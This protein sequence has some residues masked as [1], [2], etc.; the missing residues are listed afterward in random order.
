ML[1]MLT[2]CPRSGTQLLTKLCNT[3]PEVRITMELGSLRTLWV[4][5]KFY[6]LYLLSSFKSRRFPIIDDGSGGWRSRRAWWESYRFLFRLLWG[7]REFRFQDVGSREVESLYRKTT[8]C[9]VVGDKLPAYILNLEQYLLIENLRIVVIHRHPAA[10]IR[11]YL[12]LVQGNWRKIPTLNRF[13]NEAAVARLWAQS[14]EPLRRFGDRVLTIGYESLC[15]DP[16]AECR[17]LGE[18]FEVDPEGFDTSVVE[19]PRPLPC[20]APRTIDEIREVAGAEAEFL[21][22]RLS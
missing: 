22:Y 1:A 8:G 20:F 12:E 2:G 6:G 18:W 15:E 19:P 3:H 9:R 16:E 4:P 17:R 7:L 10:V 13:D 5:P 14:V 21:G 11:S